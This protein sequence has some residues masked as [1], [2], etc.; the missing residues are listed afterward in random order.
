MTSHK[1]LIDQG[2]NPHKNIEENLS[3]MINANCLDGVKLMME[4]GINIAAYD[5]LKYSCSSYYMNSEITNFLIEN[6][7]VI[8][9]IY[10]FRAI[11]RGFT[12]CVK[13]MIE[14]GVDIHY[15]NNKAV[16]IAITK[17]RH[18]ILKL[19]LQNGAVIQP[20][21]PSREENKKMKIYKILQ[22]YDT[23]ESVII[24]LLTMSRKDLNKHD[25]NNN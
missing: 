14:Y 18:E 9:P 11:E 5:L 22:D 4:I 16:L 12:D 7:A 15:E 20:L 3:S 23:K 1:Y 17:N 25:D 8:Q 19:L 10:L 2:A 21:D 6:G 13:T 24:N